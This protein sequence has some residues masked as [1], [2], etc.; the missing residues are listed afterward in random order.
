MAS[1]IASLAPQSGPVPVFIIGNK[2]WF[3]ND[4]RI[5][6]LRRDIAEEKAW[7]MESMLGLLLQF[8]WNQL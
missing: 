6:N 5:L 1:L 8:L 3:A 2:I 7:K 4:L